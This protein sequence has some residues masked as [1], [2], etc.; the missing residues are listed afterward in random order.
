M[1]DTRREVS[2]EAKR[3]REELEWKCLIILYLLGL[4]LPAGALTSGAVR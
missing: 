3:M 2:R 1:C 4:L